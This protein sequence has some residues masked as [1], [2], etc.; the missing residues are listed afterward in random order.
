MNI[1]RQSYSKPKLNIPSTVNIKESINLCGRNYSK[2]FDIDNSTKRRTSI[3]NYNES[4]QNNHKCCLYKNNQ[5]GKGIYNSINYNQEESTS[6]PNQNYKANITDRRRNIDDIP[7]VNIT[8]N[9]L[10][11]TITSQKK[12]IET[13]LSQNSQYLK[14]NDSKIYDEYNLNRRIFH[15]HSL[16][17]KQNDY[18][19]INKSG[20]KSNTSTVD[21]KN[22]Y[23][24]MNIEDLLVNEERIFHIFQNLKLSFDTRNSCIEWWDYFKNSSICGKF[25]LFYKDNQ[26]KQIIKEHMMSEII[27]IILCYQSENEMN[28]IDNIKEILITIISYLYQ[29]LLLFSDYILSKI[30]N[31]SFGNIWVRQIN[32]K[33]K[34]T[35][36]PIPVNKNENI[37]VIKYNNKNI[38]NNL[39]IIIDYF[40]RNLNK[41][42]NIDYL[43][44]IKNYLNKDSSIDNTCSLLILSDIFKNRVLKLNSLNESISIKNNKIEKNFEN[45]QNITPSFKQGNDYVKK[46]VCKDNEKGKGIIAYSLNKKYIKR[47][48]ENPIKKLSFSR[49]NLVINKENKVNGIESG[50]INENITSSVTDAPFIKNSILNKKYCLVLDLDETLIHYKYEASSP[51]EGEMLIRP[52]LFEF[53]NGVDK[54]YE[55]ILFTAG[56][57]E[58][59]L[60][61]NI[62]YLIL[63]N[64]SME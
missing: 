23:I 32:E 21:K 28:L 29:S 61:I 37:N 50:K 25:D 1:H 27:F 38:K 62:N 41:K 47:R 9:T 44:M 53:L 20:Y 2:G 45:C 24:Q 13:S 15:D 57:E 40:L 16:N 18:N 4:N 8:Y 49:Q 11:E 26:S 33:I 30:E 6:L 64:F 17:V 59:S 54:Y 55:L 7:K 34:I 22:I 3:G 42:Y 14:D 63:Y 39:L 10:H 46:D 48:E 52:Y 12:T 58:V 36:K 19:T 31:I 35:I 5:K 43:L 60:F 51:E 56:T